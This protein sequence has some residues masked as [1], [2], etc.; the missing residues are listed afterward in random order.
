MSAL[1]KFSPDDL[2]LLSA[3]IAIIISDGKSS[4]DLNV[5]GII[6][7]G[8]GTNISL[9]AAQKQFLQSKEDKIKQIQDLENQIKTLK[10][11]L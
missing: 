1:D 2:T 4:D 5:L 8:I 7:S 6:V 9:I 3:V 11:D 10:K